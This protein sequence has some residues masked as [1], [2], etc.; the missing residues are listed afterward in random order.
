MASLVG[1]CSA[2]CLCLSV[3]LFGLGMAEPEY[4]IQP[5]PG[6]LVLMC[7]GIAGGVVHQSLLGLERRTQHLEVERLEARLRELERQAAETH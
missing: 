7:L 4:W 2:A 5:L 6:W 1:L 3:A